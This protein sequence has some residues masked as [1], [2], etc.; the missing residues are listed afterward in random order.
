[1]TPH[2]PRTSPTD[3]ASR[4]SWAREDRYH[5]LFDAIDQGFCIAEVIFG[6]DGRAVDHLILE[7][8]AAFERH[9][10]VA[11]AAGRRGSELVPGGE[12]F[13]NEQYGHVVTSGESVRFE[14]GSDAMQ[15]WFEVL[16][17]RMGDATSRTIAIL[18]SDISERK[19]TEHALAHRTQQFETLLNEAPLGVYL[20][21]A[22]LRLRSVNPIAMS[23]F[24]GIDNPIGRDF[25]EVMHS[26]WPPAR[27]DEF[28]GRFRRTLASGEPFYAPDFSEVRFDSGVAEYYSW[29]INRIALPEG[30]FGVVCYY[31]EIS[32]IV[33]AKDRLADSQR[34][35]LFVMDSMP[36][37]IFTAAPDATID[38]LN[39]QWMQFTGLESDQ[40]RDWG[41]VGLI[42]PDDLAHTIAEWQRGF[43]AGE[44]IQIEHRFQRHDGEYRWHISRALPMRNADGQIQL[45][46]GSSTDIHHQK[47]DAYAKH[48]AALALS[49]ADLRKD[50]FL[51]MLAHEL[52]NPLAPIRNA[53]QILQLA[54][55]S[56]DAVRMAS[57]IIDRQTTQ[58]IRLVDELLD[59][60]RISRGNIEL[61]R[62]TVDLASVLNQAVETSRPALERAQHTLTVS[63]PAQPVY[64]FADA[65]RLVQVFGNLLNNAGKFTDPGGRIWLSAEQQAGEIVVTVRDTGVG[66]PAD[67]LTT[68]FE[69]FRQVDHSLEGSRGGLGIGLSLVQRLVELHG[70]SV[71]ASSAGP[72]QGT[73]FVVRLPVEPVPLPTVEP[74]DSARLPS[75]TTVRRRVLVVDDNH[76]SAD[77]LALYLRMLGNDTQTAYDGLDAVAVTERFRP[78]LL[79]LDIGMPR[80]NGYDAARQIRAQSWGLAMTIVAL[81]GWGQEHDRRRS[82]EAGFDEHFVKPVNHAIL[83]GF[84]AQMPTAE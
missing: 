26:L 40:V 53:L 24:A 9:T 21:D 56:A 20:V 31:R 19:R 68:I 46:V 54:E 27:A 74:S 75:A 41:R 14:Q 57:G 52:R 69:M 72:G 78:H 47:Q 37:K 22:A 55:H 3:D 79:L 42:H 83:A 49:L 77:S 17:T 84:L 70:G 33:H 28:V 11:N 62:D 59:V 29:Q 73:S 39:P 7:C 51:A 6:D 81:S 32:S 80:L 76:D 2:T 12:A 30:G 58:M 50:E 67:K 8:N 16:V 35:L 15:R 38:Y 25:D 63:A 10:G 43:E 65:V 18:F 36:Q 48:T 1:M 61:R 4:A 82:R 64:L 44:P 45:W 60:S 23:T 66:V 5:A 34:Q 13:F 71:R